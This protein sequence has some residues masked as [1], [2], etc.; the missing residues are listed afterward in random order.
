MRAVRQVAII[1]QV[2]QVGFNL[3][4][5]VLGWIAPV[6]LGQAIDG[7]DATLLRAYSKAAQH[8]RVEHAL[9]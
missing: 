8:H 5:A 3:L 1:D 6:A 9:A 4:G 7:I 2:Q